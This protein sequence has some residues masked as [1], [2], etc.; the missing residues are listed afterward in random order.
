MERKHPRPQVLYAARMTTSPLTLIP[1]R[2][3]LGDTFQ[4][5]NQQ[6]ITAMFQM[7]PG[8]EAL[9]ANP[10]T[11]ILDI[12]GHIWF[13]EHPSRGVV[14][15][16]A[17]IPRKS[18]DFELTKMG[19]L[20]DARGLGAGEFL[21]TAVLGQVKQLDVK[22]LFL[23]TSSKCEAAIHIYRKHGFQDDAEIMETYAESY[24]RCNVAML[25]HPA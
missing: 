1:F 9:L 2:P 17:I 15:T 12:G 3:E 13:V 20:E 19:V 11:A 22:R 7:E 5:I 8:D 25:W 18:G 23:L 21:L 24:A 4:S 6:W 14:G 16:A 10:Q